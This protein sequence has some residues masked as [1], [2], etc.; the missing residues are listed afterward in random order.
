[1]GTH[2]TNR[3]QAARRGERQLSD[4]ETAR[5]VVRV[6]PDVTG[7]RRQF[8]YTVPTDQRGV[9]V[10]SIVRIEL[11]RR[12]VDGWITA[13]DPSDAF[14]RERLAPVINIVSAGPTPETMRLAAWAGW[15]WA[16][17]PV[18]FLRVASPPNRVPM[19]IALG[20]TGTWAGES[21]LRLDG[22]FDVD[23]APGA[24]GGYP[25][26][27]CPPGPFPALGL[28]DHRNVVA[29]VSA[30]P[31]P[32]DRG[33]KSP[34]D[35][36]PTAHARIASGLEIE[37]RTANGSRT[38]VYVVDPVEDPTE[39]ITERLRSQTGSALVLIPRGRRARRVVS[40]LRAAGR[41][42]FSPYEA[43]AS[44]KA[45]FL[46]DI[47]T[48]TRRGDC[49]LVGGRPAVWLPFP[50]LAS[51][52]LCDDADEVWKHEASP[53]WHAREVALKRAADR[54][55]P[56]AVTSPLPTVEA[57]AHASTIS[58]LERPFSVWHRVE[59]SD[60]RSDP[61]GAGLL[62]DS[63]VAA[64]RD[65]I[66][67]E[68]RVVVVLNQKGR[69]RLLACPSCSALTACETC[70]GA[71]ISDDDGLLCGSCGARRP[72]MCQV[73]GSVSLKVLRPG[74]TRVADELASMFRDVPT[75]AIDATG[76]QRRLGMG[77]EPQVPQRDDDDGSLQRV[78]RGVGPM[79]YVGTEA[80]FHRVGSAGLVVFL[81]ADQELSAQRLR[82]K[83]QAAWLLVR[84]L[85]MTAASPL[86]RRVL[87]STRDPEHPVLDVVRTATVSHLIDSERVVRQLLRAN[88]Y[89][90]IARGRGVP[91]VMDALVQTLA[92]GELGGG[93]PLD[94]DGPIGAPDRPEY[95]LRGSGATASTQ[96][97]HAARL[98]RQVGTLRLDVD[99]LRI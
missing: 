21:P 66:E 97:A 53:A 79:I 20:D 93:A 14:D 10:G 94:V 92:S 11:Q 29:S 98:A 46:T 58:G 2:R 4:E 43:G 50:D 42:V 88:P 80:V 40:A 48:A 37:G 38:D 26:P 47:W 19:S 96:L 71:V 13:V 41:T 61:P 73:C 18:A 83:E 6:I 85:R 31:L 44:K 78:P 91:A 35:F 24:P 32:E 65:S 8:D 95:L 30:V 49:V 90:L 33:H 5:R 87:V 74:A 9:T 45:A 67:R 23:A 76:T 89:G 1:M 64:V 84:A 99:P 36:E 34:S 60:R 27:W 72:R 56:V 39:W 82:A 52:V 12:R 51:I 62:T 75:M 59:V 15:R 17:N 68:Q 7:I 69:A 3:Q 63:V 25:D 57:L 28:A 70:S 81:D 16:Y 55:I 77:V 54:Q 86:A 22:L